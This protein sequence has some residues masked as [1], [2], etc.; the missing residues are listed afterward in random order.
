MIATQ[1]Q[2]E[3]LERT[4]ASIVSESVLGYS[5]ED[6]IKFKDHTVSGPFG[7]KL[8]RYL[9]QTDGWLKSCG[10]ACCFAG[11]LTYNAL[12]MGLP[13]PESQNVCEVKMLFPER[14][15]LVFQEAF[16]G[17]FGL[18]VDEYGI[19]IDL[20]NIREQQKQAVV[21]VI[22]SILTELRTINVKPNVSCQTGH[23][24]N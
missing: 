10:T 23:S 7:K 2:I 14:Y 12:R 20:E 15:I 5:Q 11:H 1:Q 21:S 4:R 19:V 9:S 13:V 3:L 22:D 24:A 16:S 18:P 6:Y 8:R 17:S